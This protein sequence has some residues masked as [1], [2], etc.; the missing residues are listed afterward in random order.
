M[1]SLLVLSFTAKLWWNM[2]LSCSLYLIPKTGHHS[3]LTRKLTMYK[4]LN[5]FVRYSIYHAILSLLESFLKFQAILSL[6]YRILTVIVRNI[7]FVH[8]AT[9]FLETVHLRIRTDRLVWYLMRMRDHSLLEKW[10]WT[11]HPVTIWMFTV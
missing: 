6:F 10:Y 4:S 3:N 11:F 2:W 7:Y 9:L 1:V 8:F 5:R